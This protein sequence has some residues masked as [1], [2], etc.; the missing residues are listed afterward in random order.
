VGALDIGEVSGAEAGEV[1]RSLRTW[2]TL[3]L[4]S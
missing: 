2:T 4:E 1:G 3:V